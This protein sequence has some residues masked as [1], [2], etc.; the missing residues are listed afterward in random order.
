M[1]KIWPG[2]ILIFLVSYLGYSQNTQ[3]FNEKELLYSR[4]LDLF[5]KQKYNSAR[6][7]FREYIQIANDERVLESE[8]YQALSGLYLYHSDA[9]NDLKKFQSKYPEHPKSKRINFAL[10][11]FY[12]QKGDFKEAA[13]YLRNVEYDALN[14]DERIES[15]FKLAYSYFSSQDFESAAPFF[16]GVKGSNSEYSNASYYYS[17][18]I[19]YKSGKYAQAEKDL[20]MAAF[21]DSY[22]NLIPELLANIYYKQKD[23]KRLEEIGRKVLDDKRIRNRTNIYMILADANYE[24][25]NYNKAFEYFEAYSEGRSDLP[26]ANISYRIGFSAFQLGKYEY[27]IPYFDQ[28]AFRGN[29]TLVQFASYYLGRVHLK[30]GNTTYAENAFDK[31]SKSDFDKD[32]QEESF[33]ALAKLKFDSKLRAQSISLLQDYINNYPDGK[34]KDEANQYLSEAFLTSNN[35]DAAIA[36]IEG[37]SKRSRIIDETYQKVTFYKGVEHFNNRKFQEAIVLFDKSLKNNFAAEFESL[38]F[39]WKGELL[40]IQQD[41]ETAVN[42]Y[43]GV[44]RNEKD[45]NS[46]LFLKTRYG[47]A[48]AYFNTK[49]YAKALPHFKK[50]TEALAN[51][52]DKMYYADALVRLG[53]CYLVL[54]NNDEA[55]AMYLKASGIYP[56]MRFYTYFRL[57]VVSWFKGN[58]KEAQDYLNTVIKEYS[59]SRYF[60]DALFE[61]ANIDFE[62]SDFPQAIKGFTQLINS[63]EMSPYLPY[64]Y[65]NRG[66]SYT[67]IQ[68]PEKAVEDYRKILKDYPS[69]KTSVDAI[70][71]LQ[72]ALQLSGRSDEYEKDKQL[73]AK[74]NPES[75]ALVTLDFEGARNQYFGRNYQQSTKLFKTYLK[76]YGKNQFYGDVNYYLAESY[77]LQNEKDSA[78]KYHLEVLKS[79]TSNFLNK[80]ILQTAD[81]KYEKG[82]FR[83]AIPNY[84]L[85]KHLA[86]SRNEEIFAWQG[87]MESHFKLAEYDTAMAYAKLI[88][89]RGE[90]AF[91]ARNKAFL[92]LGKSARALG[93]YDDAEDYFNQCIESGEDENAAEAFY[94][95]AEM[96]S[97][98][99]DYQKS[100]DMCLDLVGRFS[101]YPKWNDASFLL[102]AQNFYLMGE[103]FQARS[104]LESIIANSPSASTVKEAQII[105]QKV[106]EKE[107]VEPENDIDNDSID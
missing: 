25:K 89:E 51:A 23:F 33:F 87:L 54:K 5:E 16:N 40:S 106:L 1:K 19:A 53:D 104:T 95:I 52:Q 74:A 102:I 92:Y 12:F 27:A 49:Q 91:G 73:F 17:G 6:S 8:Y 7:A 37:L 86:R 63:E 50:Y 22:K 44:F 82:E 78:L 13:N 71:G 10:G 57:G 79:P 94:I 103:Y 101:Q 9:V 107:I 99:G 56:E 28:A 4:A 65:L 38:A 93:K 60:D 15:Q 85:L 43:A 36:H 47:I 66:I 84:N 21:D 18:I 64:A 35:F 29:D 59:S 76:Q 100:I 55:Y 58:K 3:K 30:N 11:I 61:Y 97:N 88:T 98:L 69:H 81:I 72:E 41:Y 32:I 34:Y 62:N 20:E 77:Y 83:E 80:S 24:Q 70:T 68:K 39:F 90:A 48:Y 42:A 105:L 31:A 26:E 2:F 45:E 46:E 67:N 14:K 96:R 75:D